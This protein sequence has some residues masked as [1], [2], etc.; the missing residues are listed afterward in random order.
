MLGARPTKVLR[1]GHL[2][3]EDRRPIAPHTAAALIAAISDIGRFPTA[4]HL[5]SYLGFDPRVRQ[6]GSNSPATA[7]GLK[8]STSQFFGVIR[9]GRQRS[10][11][12]ANQDDSAV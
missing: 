3:L 5:V 2:R 8:R 12:P 6:S 1:I 4:R 11:L 10:V 9:V 7:S